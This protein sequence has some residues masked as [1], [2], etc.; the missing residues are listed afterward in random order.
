MI[1]RRFAAH[2]IATRAFASGLLGAFGL[3][4]ELLLLRLP[5][6]DDEM[7]AGEANR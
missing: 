7:G 1:G 3:V 6:V 5:L 2:P 4:I